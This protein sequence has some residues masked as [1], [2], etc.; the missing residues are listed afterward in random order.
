MP[1]RMS[2]GIEVAAVQAKGQISSSGW[3]N[4]CIGKNTS[5]LT[6]L[7]HDLALDLDLA[8]APFDIALDL[9]RNAIAYEFG[10]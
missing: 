9:A 8:L 10:S 6:L 4:C 2:S 7:A 3:L 5:R 1:S